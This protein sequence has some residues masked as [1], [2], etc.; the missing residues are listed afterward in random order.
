MRFYLLAVL[1]FSLAVALEYRSLDGSGN[2]KQNPYWGQSGSNYLRRE[3]STTYSDSIGSLRADLTSARNI[4]NLV[5]GRTLINP[6][7]VYCYHFTILVF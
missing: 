4:S 2:N 3:L 1:S 7:F 5:F 6:A